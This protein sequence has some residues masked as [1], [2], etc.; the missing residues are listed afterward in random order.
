MFFVMNTDSAGVELW[1]SDGTPSGTL[2]ETC[3]LKGHQIGGI[4]VSEQHANFL[5]NTG[6]GCTQ[7]LLDL[8]QVIEAK[9]WEKHHVRLQPE[10]HIVP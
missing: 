9:V 8:M 10:I 2:I 1:R 4:R 6:K 3:G 7:D 5:V